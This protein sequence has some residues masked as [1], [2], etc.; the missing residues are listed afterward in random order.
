MI[1]T[2]QPITSWLALDGWSEKAEKIVEEMQVE[3][4]QKSTA[5]DHANS[6]VMV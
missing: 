2:V 1:Q 6:A 3:K 4:P 5:A